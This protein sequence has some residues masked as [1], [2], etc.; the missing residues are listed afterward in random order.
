[1]EFPVD[2]FKIQIGFTANLVRSLSEATIREKSQ[3][4]IE[5][6]EEGLAEEASIR[7][8]S[9]LQNLLTFAT[10]TPNEVDRALLQGGRISY[11]DF[12]IPETLRPLL[13]SGLPA[14]RP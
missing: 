8:L 13:H 7:H 12:D 11:G 5:P 3:I 6:I 2:D 14:E 10:D 4:A 1:M 9:P